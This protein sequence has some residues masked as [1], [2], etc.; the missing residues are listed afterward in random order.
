M[1]YLEGLAALERGGTATPTQEYVRDRNT[2]K[3]PTV[4]A[5]VM[6]LDVVECDVDVS[7]FQL[8]VFLEVR[9]YFRHQLVAEVGVGEDR[10]G[11]NVGPEEV[12]VCVINIGGA[13]G[14]NYR[15]NWS[16]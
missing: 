4:S 1:F 14:E 9:E 11:G 12:S 7:L 3:Y 6:G 15:V 13:L 8:R 10:E 5:H 2:E 16:L